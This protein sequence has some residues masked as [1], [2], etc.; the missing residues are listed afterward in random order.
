MLRRALPTAR[1]SNDLNRKLTQTSGGE[2]YPPMT[3]SR[4]RNWKRHATLLVVIALICVGCSAATRRDVTSYIF[5]GVPAPPV[6]EEYCA[7]WLAARQDQ[8][9]S[10]RRQAKAEPEGSSH[11]PY[12][13]KECTKCHDTSKLGGLILPRKELCLKC[14]D[15]IIKGAYGHAPAVAGDCLVCH[16]PHDSVYPSLLK[17]KKTTIC[18]L[19]H[20][21]RRTAQSLHERAAQAK[22]A[23]SDCHDPHAGNLPYFVK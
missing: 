22:I 4:R 15:Y 12:K 6:P 9:S 3:L 1:P 21:E 10:A 17:Q 14:H 8:T 23:C 20:V 13:E 7:A 5:D 16:L 2:E 19:C 11:R 18:G